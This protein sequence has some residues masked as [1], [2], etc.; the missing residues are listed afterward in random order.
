MGAV[1]NL[2]IGKVTINFKISITKFLDDYPKMRKSLVSLHFLKN[3][4]RIMEIRIKFRIT[5]VCR[6]HSPE[7]Q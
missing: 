3:N 6:K 2:K 7:F 4:F 1:S 5:E